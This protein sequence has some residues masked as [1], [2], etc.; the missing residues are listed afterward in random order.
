MARERKEKPN[1]FQRKARKELR[2][3]FNYLNGTKNES[4][5]NSPIEGSEA[6]YRDK[7]ARKLGGETEVHIDQLGKIDILTRTEIIEVKNAKNWKHAIGQ[8]TVYG[9]H[10]PD[11]K[12]RI[13]L[14]GRLTQSKLAVI[15]KACGE[16]DVNLT[17]E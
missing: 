3:F 5:I 9:Q 15:Q 6:W 11:R 2:N 10:Y 16:T 1:F 7:L 8:I 12:K 14:F 13:H 4:A 17:W